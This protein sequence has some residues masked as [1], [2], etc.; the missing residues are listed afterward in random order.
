[1]AAAVPAWGQIPA[2][3]AERLNQEGK[4]RFAD[5]DYEGAYRKFREAAT[6]SPE[7]RFFFNACY[8]LN[9][10]GRYEEAI[11][12]CEQVAATGADARLVD[13]TRQ[14]LASL[15][16]KAAAGR[17]DGEGRVAT[18]RTPDGGR[19]ASDVDVSGAGRPPS[20]AG[21]GPDPFV[22]GR[23]PRPRDGYTWSIGGAVGAIGNVDVGREVADGAGGD[24]E[25][26]GAGGGDFRL[27]ANFIVSEKTRLGLQGSLGF[28]TLRPGDDNATGDSLLLGDIGAAVFLHVPLAGRVALTPLLGPFLSVQKPGGLSQGFIA[29]GARAELGISYGFGRRGEHAISLIPAWNLYFPASGDVEGL[30]P[31]D[32]GLDVTHSTFGLAAGYAYRFSTPFGAVPLITLE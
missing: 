4:R 7:G 28:G 18:G 20:P 3:Q 22:E 24:R 32:F 29:G 27:F 8:A 6:L 25:I 1:M 30:T 12:A 26:Y 19:R 14:A 10:L 17:R 11:Q 5:E 23:A 13:K 9:F 2:E 16:E 21:L 31:A 15:R